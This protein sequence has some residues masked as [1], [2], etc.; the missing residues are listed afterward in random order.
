M[1][2]LGGRGRMITGRR[3]LV[4]LCALASFALGACL[5]VGDDQGAVL[6]IELFW[7]ERVGS[8]SF[9]G[10][11]CHSAGVERMDWS[12]R[13]DS[14]AEVAG[15][16]EVCADTIDVLDSVPGRYELSITGYDENDD[17][18]WRAKCTELLVLRFDVGYRC[19]I[20]A[21]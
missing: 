4:V 7:D 9:H 16:E 6:R 10:G 11:T 2:G 19:D 15:N 18:K 17:E 5:T 1:M 8:S 21:D 12:L 13:D 3:F 20:D 14:G